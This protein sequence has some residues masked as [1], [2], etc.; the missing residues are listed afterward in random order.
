MNKRADELP[1]SNIHKIIAK[2][3]EDEIKHKNWLE[4]VLEER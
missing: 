4:T 2:G 3:L 1:G